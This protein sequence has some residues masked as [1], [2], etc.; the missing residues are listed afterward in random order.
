[1]FVCAMRLYACVQRPMHLLAVQAKSMRS[2]YYGLILKMERHVRFLSRW[3]RSRSWFFGILTK[4]ARIGWDCFEFRTGLRF[5]CVRLPL[6]FDFRSSIVLILMFGLALMG[7][8]GSDLL[9]WILK[10]L[11][12]LIIRVRCVVLR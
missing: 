4:R 2:F 3:V 6:V 9:D 11:V 1:M 10:T 8:Y 5:R 12:L 7:A